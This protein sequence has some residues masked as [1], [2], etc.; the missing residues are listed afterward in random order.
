AISTLKRM[1]ENYIRILNINFGWSDHTVSPSVIYRAVHQY[2]VK[3]VEFH[4]DLDGKGEEYSTGH[5]WLPEQ[6]KTVIKTIEDGFIAD[7]SGEIEPT[8]SELA[9]RDW[10]ADPSDGLRPLKNIRYKIRDGEI[11]L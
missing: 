11:K 10:R 5:C 2:G 1:L 6:I 3:Y 9:D 4:L 7:G 8:P